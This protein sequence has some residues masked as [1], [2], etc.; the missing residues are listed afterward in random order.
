MAVNFV[1][2]MI[3]WLALF[4]CSSSAKRVR[5]CTASSQDNVSSQTLHEAVLLGVHPHVLTAKSIMYFTL[6]TSCGTQW[7]CGI[8]CACRNKQVICA[9][10]KHKEAKGCRQVPANTSSYLACRSWQIVSNQKLAVCPAAKGKQFVCRQHTMSL[11]CLACSLT[12]IW[13]WLV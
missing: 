12:W 2:L 13:W 9:L 3:F 1:G 5:G 10:L 6:S 4:S 7:H 8:A 11:C